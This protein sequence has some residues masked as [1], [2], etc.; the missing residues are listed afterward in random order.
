MQTKLQEL[1]E[2]IYAEGLEKGKKEAEILLADAQKKADAII[3]EAEKEADELKKKTEKENNELRKNVQN[4]L[5]LSA[6]QLISD[7]QQKIASLIETKTIKPLVSNVFEDTN[8]TGNMVLNLIEKWQPEDAGNVQ[9]SVLL[10]KEKQEAFEDFFKNKVG[11]LLKNELE[12]KFS[13]KF[14]GGLKI[15][16]KEGGYMI[17]FTEEDFENLF[18]TYLR[19]KLID[20]LYNNDKQQQ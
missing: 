5:Q 3:S 18:R 6:K 2:K 11:D 19:P 7:L 17:S 9:I 10:P 14:K 13:D 20:L 16:P 8:F 15:G 4:E 1:T 12:I